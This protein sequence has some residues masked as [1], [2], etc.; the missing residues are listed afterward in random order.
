MNYD[1]LFTNL[2][3]ISK[4]QKNGRLK[5]SFNGSLSLESTSIF[6]PIVRFV[7]RDSRSQSIS[8]IR[9]IV[10]EAVHAM[11]LLFDSKYIH[12]TRYRSTEDYSKCI[13]TLQTILQ[14]LES[15]NVG[16][17]NLKFTYKTD[18][19]II[20]TLDIISMRITKTVREFTEKL[21][22]VLCL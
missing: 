4:I 1:D 12:D 15:A 13:D 3:I 9:G 16:I 11:D 6:L 8:E 10:S 14:E 20:A 17:C 19:N 2:R 22:V 5:K 7:N 18:N 21:K